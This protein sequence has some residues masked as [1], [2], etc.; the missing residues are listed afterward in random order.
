MVHQS[1]NMDSDIMDDS[2]FSVGEESEGYVPEKV[3]A[4]ICEGRRDDDLKRPFHARNL[5][6]RRSAWH[7]NVDF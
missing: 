2:A 1:A 4:L 7:A 3:S 6:Y 5:A